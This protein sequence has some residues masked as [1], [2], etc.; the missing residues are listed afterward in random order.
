MYDVQA[1]S[2]RAEPRIYGPSSGREGEASS[3][4]PGK[5]LCQVAH[6]LGFPLSSPPNR[7]GVA[8]KFAPSA[9]TQKGATLAAG[10]AFETQSWLWD[11]RKTG[12][13]ERRPFQ[14]AGR[15]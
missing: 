13:G 15:S 3:Y 7:E 2:Q 14:P 10:C 4:E 9:V 11:K 8:A 1:T 5:K 6:H 12:M